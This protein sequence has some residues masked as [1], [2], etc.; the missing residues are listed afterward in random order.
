[1][2]ELVKKIADLPPSFHG[3]GSISPRVLRA[4]VRHGDGKLINT[5]ETG[6]GRSTLLFSHLSKN[7]KVFA[8]DDGNSI[9]AVRS[10]DLFNSSTVEF[11]EL[12]T[13]L[14]LPTYTFENPL[15]MAFIDGPHGYP[16]PDLEYYYVYPHLKEGGLLILDDIDIPTI[17]NIYKFLREDA[18][19]E[20][21]EVVDDTAFF[22][23]TS[24]P[25]H[26][27]FADGWWLQNYNKKRWPKRFRTKWVHLAVKCMPEKLKLAI[28]KLRS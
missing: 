13:Q 17:Y 3:A 14:S 27:P 12:P 21:L 19:F 22:K 24:A 4:L 6:C 8:V 18:M 23:R 11:I 9:S 1:M 10:S 2:N 15:D 26:D 20:L 28:K 25:V 5:M 16:F 7:H